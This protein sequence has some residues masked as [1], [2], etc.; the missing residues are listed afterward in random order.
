MVLK[1]RNF[2][3]ILMHYYCYILYGNF[4]EMNEREKKRRKEGRR[5]SGLARLVRHNSTESSHR[6]EVVEG[7][8]TIRRVGTPDVPS[9]N[10]IVPNEEYEND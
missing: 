10:F 8:R 1:T 3:R 7:S 4:K 9:D 5:E 6:T 2:Y